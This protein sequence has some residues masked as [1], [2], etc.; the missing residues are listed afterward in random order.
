MLRGCRLGRLTLPLVRPGP[1]GHILQLRKGRISVNVHGGRTRGVFRD[2]SLVDPVRKLVLNPDWVDPVPPDLPSPPGQPGLVR[3]E[4]RDSGM[5]RVL[6]SELEAAGVEL[7]N[8]DASRLR[9][10][11]RGQS[12]PLLASGLEDGSFDPVDTLAFYA[13]ALHGDTCF[14]YP[15]ADTNV[16]W[17]DWRGQDAVRSYLI[18]RAHFD[19]LAPVDSVFLDHLHLEREAIYHDGDDELS[20][21]LTDPVPGEGWIWRRLFPGDEH[22]IEFELRDLHAVGSAELRV[23]VRGIGPAHAT[24]R[25]RAELN[26]RAL[27]EVE[28]PNREDRVLRLGFP[29]AVLQ[30]GP[31]LLRLINSTSAVSELSPWNL[32]WVEISY[33]RRLV[34]RENEGLDVW[35]P[36]S[37]T[38]RSWSVRLPGARPPSFLLVDRG[39]RLTELRVDSSHVDSLLVL[40]AGFEDGDRCLI[41]VAGQPIVERGSRGVNVVALD[42]RTGRILS[43]RTFDTHRD[44]AQANALANFLL[45]LPEGAIVLVAIRDEGSTSLTER[46]RQALEMFG[47]TLI[48]R[49]GFRDAWAMIGRKGSTPGT[50]PETWVP[51]GGGSALLQTRLSF[52]AGGAPRLLWTDTLALP[53]HLVIAGLEHARAPHRIARDEAGHLLDPP[54]G[55]ECVIITPGAFRPAAERLRQRRPL[56]TA[57]VDVQDIYDEFS[58]GLK[59]PQ[60]IRDFLGYAFWNWPSPRP[61][62]VLLLGDA[63]WDPKRIS[64]GAVFRDLVPS[65]GNP[66]SDSRLVCLDGPGDV[67]PDLPIGRIPANTLQEAEAV[68]DKLLEYENQRPGRWV[69]RALFIAGGV[70]AFEQELFARQSKSVASNF[71]EPPPA[72]MEWGLIQKTTAGYV[73]GERREDI[74]RGIDRGVLW[75]N[76]IGHAGSYTWD[77]MFHN[78]DVDALHNAPYYPFVTSMTCHTA[79]FASPYQQCLGERF[80]VTPRRGAIAFFGTSGWG[81]A[82]QDEIL[83]RQL[84]SVVLR[85]TVRTVGEAVWLAKLRYW[86]STS[87]RAVDQVVLDQYTLLGDPALRLA[88]PEEPDLAIAPEDLRILPAEPVA[89]DTVAR[90]QLVVWNY[91]LALSETCDVQI[92]FRG[93]TGIEMAPVRLPI[94]ALGRVDSLS[95][96]CR[97]PRTPGIYL[98][99]ATLDPEQ[100][101]RDARRD[102]N[103]AAIQ[104]RVSAPG[105]EILWPRPWG[106]LPA[107]QPLKIYVKPPPST[108]GVILLH[109]EIDS[110]PT[111]QSVLREARP[112]GPDSE[113]LAIF[114]FGR[115]RAGLYYCRVRAYVGAEPT[116]EAVFPFR[117]VEGLEGAGWAQ[118]GIELGSTEGSGFRASEEG[119]R[120][121]SRHS[122]VRLESAGIDDGDFARA[123][124]EGLPPMDGRPGINVVLMGPTGKIQVAAFNPEASPAAADSLA[125]LLEAIPAGHYVAMAIRRNGSTGLTERLLRAMESLGSRYGRNL[126]YGDSWAFLARAGSPWTREVWKRRGEGT[127]TLVDSLLIFAEK[128]EV[129][130]P[131]LGPSDRWQELRASVAG[132]AGKVYLAL[133]GRPSPTSPETTLVSVELQ[134]PTPDFRLPLGAIDVRYL[135]PVV[136]ITWPDTGCS[137][138]RWGVRFSQPGELVS[139][140]LEVKPDVPFVGS[141]I[142]F[143][144]FVRNLGP[145]STAAC[146]V[147]WQWQDATGEWHRADLP[148]RVPALS[149]GGVYELR[150]QWQARLEPGAYKIRLLLDPEDQVAELSEWNNLTIHHLTLRPDSAGP[151]IAILADGRPLVDGDYVPAETRLEIHVEDIG[152]YSAEDSSRLRVALDGVELRELVGGQLTVGP[153]PDG[154]LVAS[155]PLRLEPGSHLLEVKAWD[156]SGNCSDLAISLRV[157]TELIVDR[158]MNYPNPFA[159]QTLFTYFLSTPADRV[160]IRVFT[161]A[162]REVW[163]TD[164]APALAG[165]NAVSWDGCDADGAPLANGVYLYLVEAQAGSESARVLSKLA[166]LR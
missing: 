112:L 55:A 160:T 33:P 104:V 146:S 142:D 114:D 91:G 156:V 28:F 21:K 99:T 97:L 110:T 51:R 30:E 79:R 119:I 118:Q 75:V 122:K 126:G 164:A 9:L 163:S 18:Q 67:V 152:P 98:L 37:P 151:R 44:T 88:L 117:T 13:P 85:D 94:F 144:A 131:W 81:F 56:P 132:E 14:F 155:F 129:V 100:K 106:E 24:A 128:A 46:A 26:G 108:G 6:G 162:G 41:S 158:V 19:P 78:R 76:F 10:N 47:S 95:C 159:N 96:S 115:V 15:Y 150:W 50:V 29:A 60:A 43:V 125:A 4:L 103:T 120:L 69:K 59:S 116:G 17:L 40:S 165:F 48:R 5:V 124:I 102:N 1:G 16:F 157:A 2:S 74:L 92:G 65:F 83:L 82:Y 70:D 34:L 63:S 12:L 73:D 77:L 139:T 133:M 53:K 11:H 111:F 143:S 49:V 105:P 52:P 89:T 20:I 71:F 3:L 58:Y 101:T 45:A 136:T 134:A 57:I 31:N 32:D 166:I 86:A 141:R 62:L 42:D 38:P 147:A 66:V 23:K 84:A 27:P 130:G 8:I 161:L 153:S 121:A 154:E 68:I 61:H 149:P 127:A 93:G 140:P 109:A 123:E 135:R 54:S 148:G 35:L 36:P 39:I 145:G 25:L 113:S 137:L 22:R 72:A 7:R 90:V 64:E 87:N 107:D 138:A 80:L